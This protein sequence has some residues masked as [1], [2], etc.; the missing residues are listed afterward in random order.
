MVSDLKIR[1]ATKN[2]FDTIKTAIHE[3]LEECSLANSIY[4]SEHNPEYMAI[5]Y[6]SLRLELDKAEEKYKNSIGYAVSNYER[7]T[8]NCSQ[9]AGT[10]QE[11]LWG[12]TEGW[13]CRPCNRCGATGKS[14]YKEA[15]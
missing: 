13:I 14:P 2:F 9:C 5:A 10:G 1:K 3:Y 15:K 12:S 8:G 7:I 11:S 6:T 4:Y